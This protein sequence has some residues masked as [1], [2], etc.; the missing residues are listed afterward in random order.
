MENLLLLSDSNILNFVSGCFH[1]N[2]II[3]SPFCFICEKA[4]ITL[5][6]S[7]HFPYSLQTH[8][9]WCRSALQ[10]CK[11]I[12]SQCMNDWI[13]V[14][15]RYSYSLFHKKCIRIG[16]YRSHLTKIRILKV[17]FILGK[18]AIRKFQHGVRKTLMLEI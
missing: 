4:V 17:F 10:I 11:R 7:S 6:F 18:L 13:W 3:Y 12:D 14:E 9:Y 8:Y 15:I 16:L 2:A 5:K 1:R